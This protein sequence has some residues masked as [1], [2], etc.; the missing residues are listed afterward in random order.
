ML[1]EVVI[2]KRSKTKKREQVKIIDDFERN[3]NYTRQSATAPAL[4]EVGVQAL[5]E[6]RAIGVPWPAF[7]TP[8]VFFVVNFCYITVT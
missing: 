6:R 2:K 7:G 3:T 8:V 5:G 4:F 1:Y